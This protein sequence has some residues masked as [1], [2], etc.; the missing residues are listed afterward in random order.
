[1][2]LESLLKSVSEELEKNGVKQ[3]VAVDIAFT[4]NQKSSSEVELECVDSRSRRSEHVH[5]MTVNVPTAKKSPLPAAV[6]SADPTTIQTRQP[7]KSPTA[8]VAA[9]RD[10][11]LLTPP[12][13]PKKLKKW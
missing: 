2:T 6:Q 3:S 10:K 5:R 7:K 11:E 1:M 12:A 8:P 4:V 9:K 13:L